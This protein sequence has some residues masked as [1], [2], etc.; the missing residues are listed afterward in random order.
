MDYVQHSACT[1]FII[2]S[3]CTSTGQAFRFTISGD[4]SQIYGHKDAGKDLMITANDSDVRPRITLF[5]DSNIHLDTAN[6][7]IFR[8]TGTSF[9]QLYED[10]TDDVIEG[11]TAGND[12]K[13]V[14]VEGIHNY[15]KAGEEFKLF[16]GAVEALRVT[17]AAATTTIAGSNIAL[18]D[19]RLEANSINTYPHIVLT[20]SDNILY[21]TNTGRAHIFYEGASS[22]LSLYEDG[23]DDVIEGKTTN[24]D[25]YLLPDGTG[26][27]K[28]GAYNAKGAETFDGFI[29]IKDAAGNDRKLM[30][31]N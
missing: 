31:C 14:G 5:G 19:L 10:G 15:F 28:F 23:T 30:T 2:H 4:F 7:I 22:F 9:L 12:L 25:L 3:T 27:V 24:N 18:D 16:D 29:P 1:D 13:I 26:V 11:L 6:S 8:D 20:G 21:R 17:Y